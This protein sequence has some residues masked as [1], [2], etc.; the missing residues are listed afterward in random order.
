M[1]TYQEI[2]KQIGD[3]WV[4]AIKQVEETLVQYAE[5]AQNAAP[6]FETP[7]IP[8]PEAVAQFTESISQ[9]LP[10]PLEVV[11]ANFE[12][13]ERLLHAQRDLTLR[14]LEV[15]NDA[16]GAQPVQTAAAAQTAAT[17][18]GKAAS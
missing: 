15:G 4:G 10:K 3:Q 1:P 2:A 5:N 7:D 11:Q 12:L 9:Q 13:T 6:T 14:L 16:A 18:R 17:K 8:T